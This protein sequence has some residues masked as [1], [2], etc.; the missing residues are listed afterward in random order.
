ML[1][2]KTFQ[3][4]NKWFDIYIENPLKTYNKVK[5]YFRPLKIKGN[6]NIYKSNKA[7]ILEL[8]S[9]DLTWKDKFNSP[10]HEFN[11]RITLSLFNYFHLYIEWTLKEDSMT[12]MVY[13]EAILDWLY[14]GK[15]LQR[16]CTTGWSDWNEKTQKW[17]KVPFVLLKEP[18]QNLFN[19]NLLTEVKY[20]V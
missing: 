9:Y 16:A 3:I 10:R 19:K 17:E 7:K 11:P 6:F 12:D 18:Y 8:N 14:Y 20:H 5:A 2:K 15:D 13:W 4:R 1:K